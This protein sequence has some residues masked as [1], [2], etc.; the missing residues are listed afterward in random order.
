MENTQ[1]LFYEVSYFK[2]EEDGTKI[3]GFLGEKLIFKGNSLPE[4][5]EE[6]PK[7]NAKRACYRLLSKLKL[8]YS[9]GEYKFIIYETD[10]DEENLL[11]FKGGEILIGIEYNKDD[12]P[13]ESY[14]VD[15]KF[16]LQ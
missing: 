10:P 8:F 1:R 9:K 6:D 2:E 4:I 12:I 13:H 11:V 7:K 3:I 15:I 14:E 16:D 5:D